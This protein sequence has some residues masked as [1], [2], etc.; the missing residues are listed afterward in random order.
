[1]PELTGQILG[2]KRLTFIKGQ[3]REEE[4]SVMLLKFSRKELFRKLLGQWTAAIRH[5]DN[6][7]H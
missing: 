5:V 6:I 3:G 1:M 7:V 4:W 2:W